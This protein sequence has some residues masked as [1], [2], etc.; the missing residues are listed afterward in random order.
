M[1]EAIYKTKMP[2]K[3]KVIEER[4]LK[5]RYPGPGSYDP[6]KEGSKSFHN[7]YDCFGST[8]FPTRSE[9]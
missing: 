5:D 3:V 6:H 2:F 4:K 8:L 1:D 7:G 9:N